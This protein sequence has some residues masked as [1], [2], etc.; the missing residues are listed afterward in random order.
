MKRKRKTKRQ[1]TLDRRYR[2]LVAQGAWQPVSTGVVRSSGHRTAH[3]HPD[4]PARS[5]PRSTDGLIR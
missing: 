4:A 1:R 3:N 5:K 2:R